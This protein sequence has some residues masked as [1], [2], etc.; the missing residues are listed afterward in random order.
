MTHDSKVDLSGNKNAI[1]DLLTILKKNVALKHL[2][3]SDC[4]I[5]RLPDGQLC[6]LT[7]LETLDLSNNN[8]TDLPDELSRLKKLQ[9]L[10]LSHN[11]SFNSIPLILSIK[12]INLSN[13][14]LDGLPNNIDKLTQLEE[15]NLS[16]NNFF[17]ISHILKNLRLNMPTITKI[18]FKRNNI[19]PNKEML[20]W[21]EKVRQRHI[22]PVSLLFD[23]N[24]SKFIFEQFSNRL[25][26]IFDD[27]ESFLKEIEIII[28]LYSLGVQERSEMRHYFE[29]ALRHIKDFDDYHLEG[30]FWLEF[31]LDGDYLEEY[32]TAKG[33]VL[34][35]FELYEEAILFYER[36]DCDSIVIRLANLLILTK[37]SDYALKCYDWLIIRD[38]HEEGFLPL[39]QEYFYFEKSRVLFQ[40]DRLED[41]LYACDLAWKIKPNRFSSGIY[42]AGFHKFDILHLKYSVLLN[43]NRDIEALDMLDLIIT[44]FNPKD[45]PFYE[46]IKSAEGTAEGERMKWLKKFEYNNFIEWTEKYDHSIICKITLLSMNDRIYDALDQAEF[47]LDRFKNEMGF[48]SEIDENRKMHYYQIITMK[49]RFLT[50]LERYEEAEIAYLESLELINDPDIIL[51]YATSLISNSEFSKAM[52]VLQ[53]GLTLYP[54]NIKMLKMLDNLNT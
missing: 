18:N 33:T 1:L 51:L 22:R 13:C 27:P 29:H 19:I 2:I 15:I 40:L 20:L 31:R 32:W 26:P 34:E 9:S 30:D 24:I 17:Y 6:R 35:F 7:N 52:K 49:A 11:N 23:G 39:A 21:M 38:P 43:L 46:S 42:P 37:K 53:N 25:S 45:T 50:Q 12:K 4:Q 48:N 16:G 8:L 41:A 44:D 5:D 3:L 28:N 10:D 47:T 54:D 14:N 36:L